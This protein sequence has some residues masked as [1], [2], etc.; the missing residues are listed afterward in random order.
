MGKRGVGRLDSGNRKELMG[1]PAM[2]TQQVV[3]SPVLGIVR[4]RLIFSLFTNTTM[5]Y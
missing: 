4:L 1:V 3:S 5:L 2:H